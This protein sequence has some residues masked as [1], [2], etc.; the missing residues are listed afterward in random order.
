MKKEA[1]RLSVN[2]RGRVQGVGFRWSVKETS[3]CRAVT[4]YVK[5]LGDG[6]VEM[7]A[8]GEKAEVERFLDAVE[9]RM[10]GYVRERTMD[11]RMG[12]RQFE[13]FEI[14]Y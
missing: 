13:R 7:V 4:G 1:F 3:T 9:E 14:A 2:F 6:S 11:G 12:E 10:S 8:E 5:N